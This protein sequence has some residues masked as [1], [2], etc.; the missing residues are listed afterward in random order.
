MLKKIIILTILGTL[1]S[2]KH[3]HKINTKGKN[4]SVTV[5]AYNRKC[6]SIKMKKNFHSEI[7]NFMKIPFVAFF[8]NVF[9]YY[10]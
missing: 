4:R 9:E 6:N 7:F 8:L 1:N 10:L 3:F 5:I 2:L